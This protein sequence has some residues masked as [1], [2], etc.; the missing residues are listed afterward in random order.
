MISSVVIRVIN[1]RRV[2]DRAG[3]AEL[4]SAALT[5]V[6]NWY[7]NRHKTGFPE[8]IDDKWWDADD[9]ETFHHSQQAARS[10]TPGPIDRNG[11]PTELINSTELARMLGYA[12]QK[13]LPQSLLDRADVAEELPSGYRRRRWRRQTGWNYADSRPGPGRPKRRPMID[14]SGDPHEL[15]GSAEA[16]RVLGYTRAQNLPAGLLDRA[17]D[18]TTRKNGTVIRQWR[19]RTLWDWHDNHQP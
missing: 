4:T 3:I 16:A 10:A 13:S 8:R 12:N 1:G 9:V 2:A 18:T 11:D 14:R 19:R 5:T 17:D 7:S 15:V 6:D